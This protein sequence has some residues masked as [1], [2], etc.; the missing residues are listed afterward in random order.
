MKRK[1]LLLFLILFCFSL[2]LLSC[3]ESTPESTPDSTVSSSASTADTTLPA[4][5]KETSTAI[6]AI[7]TA[8]ETTVAV[9]TTPPETEAVIPQS[10]Y[11]NPSAVAGGQT[12]VIP[13]KYNE[14]I[15]C[16]IYPEVIYGTLYFFLPSTADLSKVVYETY[17]N[18]GA[19]M[20]GRVADFTSDTTDYK[21]IT[22]ARGSPRL[23]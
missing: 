8:P 1:F 18:N 11:T 17:T 19:F 9:T 6:P 5:A 22:L 12:I 2:A 20:M 7:S 14:G 16:D 4:S 15:A 21:K 23:Q 3:G 13:A 10:Y